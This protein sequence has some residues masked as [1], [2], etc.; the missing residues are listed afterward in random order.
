MLSFDD[1]EEKVAMRFEDEN[2]QDA[3]YEITKCKY[4]NP[5]NE[6]PVDLR[7]RFFVWHIQCETFRRN[8]G[9]LQ[10]KK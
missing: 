10:N 3:I 2:G 9:I 1:T 4:C 8:H 6:L 5:E 7:I